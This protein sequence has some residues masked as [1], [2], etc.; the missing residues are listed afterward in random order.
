MELE[1]LE[2]EI[3]MS[4]WNNNHWDPLSRTIITGW[5]GGHSLPKVPHKKESLPTAL[6]Y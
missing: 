5:N 3:S 2:A 4:R 1:R 6:S